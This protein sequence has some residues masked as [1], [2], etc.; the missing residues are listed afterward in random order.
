MLSATKRNKT[1]V[2]LSRNI[3]HGALTHWLVCLKSS[4]NSY[5]I[6]N[7]PSRSWF[8]ECVVVTRCRLFSI[9]PAKL[10]YKLYHIADSE[11]V[12]LSLLVLLSIST[13][14]AR[15][16]FLWRP[17]NGW[18]IVGGEGKQTQKYLGWIMS[19]RKCNHPC[20]VISGFLATC[21][22]RCLQRSSKCTCQLKADRFHMSKTL[23]RLLSAEQAAKI[24]IY[25]SEYRHSKH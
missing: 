18:E 24:L 8:W 12:A 16:S 6:C 22:M 1:P 4:W 9:S 20:A 14:P 23:I 11:T 21:M 15:K 5:L 13:A 2:C 7:K 19:G 25:L 3:S 10:H 17:K